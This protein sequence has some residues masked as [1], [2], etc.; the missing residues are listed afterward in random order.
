M[1]ILATLAHNL[2]IWLLTWSAKNGE[3]HAVITKVTPDGT[4]TVQEY[5]SKANRT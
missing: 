1:K 4:E 5:G 2:G 3:G